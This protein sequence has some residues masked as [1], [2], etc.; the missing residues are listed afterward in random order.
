MDKIKYDKLPPDL[1]D[2]NREIAY[3]IMGYHL[4]FETREYCTHIKGKRVNLCMEW[5]FNPVRS[6]EDATRAIYKY[7]SQSEMS[8]DVRFSANS[9]EGNP[10]AI[11]KIQDARICKE[12]YSSGDSLE[13]AI[14]EVLIRATKL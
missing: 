1:I 11:A 2:I 12:F 6:I 3:K 7:C 14:C 10:H 9:W 8:F 5:D 4:D 13:I